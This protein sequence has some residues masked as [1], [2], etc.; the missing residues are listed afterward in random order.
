[1]VLQWGKL[2]R[3]RAFFVV[4]LA[5]VAAAS[6]AAVLLH[7][8]PAVPFWEK[9]ESGGYYLVGPP[10][11]RDR[12]RTLFAILEGGGPE[13]AFAATREISAVF[14]AEGENGRL[15]SFLGERMAAFPEDPYGGF[16]LLTVA[17]AHL[18]NGSDAVALR[19]FDLL[20]RNF[21]DVRVNG[22]SVHFLA[23]TQLIE[24][25]DNPYR[26]LSYL[27]ELLSR[28]P[29]RVDGPA[30][31]YRLALVQESLGRWDDAM[32]SYS[33]FLARGTG[34]IH[35]YPEAYDEARRRVNLYHSSRNWTFDS[36]RSLADSVRSAVEAGNGA[37]LRDMQAGANF[38]TRSWGHDDIVAMNRNPFNVAGFMRGAQLHAANDFHRS[39]TENEVLMR[40]WGWPM[41]V[42]VWYMYFRKVDFPA[43]PSVHGRWE[44]A[45]IY[46]GE[47][48]R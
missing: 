26:Q 12:L 32:D 29:D 1:M 27:D 37:R 42:P 35:G 10:E 14:L 9:P 44:W 13:E 33:R 31:L 25:N 48:L 3:G 4:S 40:T 6:V 36:L 43:D 34:P 17:Y 24:L 23:L 47:S 16:H 39:S 8:A 30:L 21:P 45:G 7:A 46:F 18:R 11:T 22:E 15:I 2:R 20:V 38:F 5:V 41:S 19:Y 28:F